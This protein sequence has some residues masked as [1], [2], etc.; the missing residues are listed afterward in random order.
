MESRVV[1]SPTFR[2]I[3]IDLAAWPKSHDLFLSNSTE[4][5]TSTFTGEF[6]F[7]VAPT[8][9]TLINGLRCE[10][11]IYQIADYSG[12]FWPWCFTLGRRKSNYF[13]WEF[14]VIFRDISCD[15]RYSGQSSCVTHFVDSIEFIFIINY[16]FS[17]DIILCLRSRILLIENSIKHLQMWH[18]SRSTTEGSS[19][20]YGEFRW[21]SKVE[22][23]KI[24]EVA[25]V[26]F[27]FADNV[28]SSYLIIEIHVYSLHLDM[29]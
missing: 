22:H 29:L 5:E 10:P 18:G 12:I 17:R 13:D 25:L 7:S 20:F 16:L 28:P 21:M 27:I 3:G 24:Y 19:S 8:R 15:L 1:S 23:F 6:I 9:L 11:V 4:A 14:H 26:Y 2:D